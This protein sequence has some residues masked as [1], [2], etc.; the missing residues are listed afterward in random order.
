M[1]TLTGACLES[2]PPKSMLA[3]AYTA[4][5]IADADRYVFHAP[6]QPAEGEAQLAAAEAIFGQASTGL[7]L[8][9]GLLIGGVAALES[10][11]QV[12]AAVAAH[13]SPVDYGRDDFGQAMKLAAQLIQADLGVRVLTTTLAGF[14]THAN[15]GPTL[16]RL[17]GQFSAGVDAFMQDAVAGGFA[18][19][20]A[21]LAWTEL[22]RRVAENASGGTDH[23]TAAP[24]FLIGQAVA[25]GVH[26]SHPSLTDLDAGNLRMAIDFRSVY[27]GVLADWL[28]VDPVA[29]LGEDWPRPALFA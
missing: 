6:R 19:R 9:D 26:G 14:D 5:A 24:M 12:Q 28:G 22:G 3:T 21:I 27:A 18:D 13:D 2:R 25:G 7:P 8:F 15:Q 29:I 20:V 10:V 11:D 16:E 4:P 23:G 17:L 1:D